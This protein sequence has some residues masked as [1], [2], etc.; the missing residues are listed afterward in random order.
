MAYTHSV[1]WVMLTGSSAVPLV[2]LTIREYQKTFSEALGH[3]MKQ[4]RQDRVQ[5]D[6]SD[7][8]EK[9]TKEYV[10]GC[11]MRSVEE[12]NKTWATLETA[13]ILN[14]EDLDTKVAP[15]KQSIRER[16]KELLPYKDVNVR[17]YLTKPDKIYNDIDVIWDQPVYSD[18]N[19]ERRG[20]LS[21]LFCRQ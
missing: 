3:Q 10:M 20:C 14:D 18:G 15:Y 9:L 16:V 1:L 6:I 7:L 4:H 8:M 17:V 19:T 12:G 11:V 13:T 5:K 21:V 2:Q